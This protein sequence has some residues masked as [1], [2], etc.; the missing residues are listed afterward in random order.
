MKTKDTLP[1]KEKVERLLEKRRKQRKEPDLAHVAHARV[2][3]S[4]GLLLAS[5]GVILAFWDFSVYGV[6][7]TG[8]F[9]TL[10]AAIF[11]RS[12]ILFKP[13]GRTYEGKAIW[14]GVRKTRGTSLKYAIF[15][16]E[17]KKHDWRAGIIA[18]IILLVFVLLALL[19]ICCN[20]GTPDGTVGLVGWIVAIGMG[21]FF[22]FI[23]GLT[24][25]Y[26]WRNAKP[27]SV[28]Q[29]TGKTVLE[30]ENFPLV[31][32][33]QN[34]LLVRQYCQPDEFYRC[35][36]EVSFILR[37]SDTLM[38]RGGGVAQD[39][40]KER[41]RHC[42]YTHEIDK[43]L[44]P[45]YEFKFSVFLPPDDYIPSTCVSFSSGCVELE[46]RLRLKIHSG[47]ATAL[48]REFPVIIRAGELQGD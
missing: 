43:T 13:E 32:G 29:S 37:E 42:V 9:F 7:V 4:L 21:A 24:L 36:A 28:G 2:G 26:H 3:L 14:W 19:G 31:I 47:R 20:L 8:A 16:D 10:V 6:C 40:V 41:F 44:D 1:L 35:T 25:F 33:Q 17:Q 46:W 39:V 30:T 27:E 23:A 5:V 45:Y 34:E 11:I 12:V 15:C 18:G 22:V 38:A 48:V